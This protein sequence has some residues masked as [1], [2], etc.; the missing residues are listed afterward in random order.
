MRGSHDFG[1]DRYRYIGGVRHRVGLVR[2]LLPLARET[3]S[4]FETRIE[5]LVRQLEAMAKVRSVAVDFEIRDGAI[6]QAVL[7]VEHDPY[8]EF[9][10][11]D[12]HPAGGR[13]AA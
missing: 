8:V 7:D 13:R 9:I 3:N 4:Q 11:E 6:V 1:Q 5:V 12:A 2:T 10:A